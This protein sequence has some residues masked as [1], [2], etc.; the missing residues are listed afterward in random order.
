MRELQNLLERLCLLE[1]GDTIRREHLP[2]RILREVGAPAAP[3]RVVPAAGSSY[4]EVTAQFR[5]ALIEQTLA[6]CGNN[7]GKAAQSLNLSRHALRHQMAKL[8]LSV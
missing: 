4:H 6:D 3:G 5:R 2:A 8:V 7:V 1:D